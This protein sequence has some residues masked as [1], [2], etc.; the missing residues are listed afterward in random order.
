MDIPFLIA[1]I[2]LG[3]LLPRPRGLVGLAIAWS[4][5]I[6]LVGW[7]PLG[8]SN[9]HTDSVGFWLPWLVVGALGTGLVLV[10]GRFRA[11]RIRRATTS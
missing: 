2:M 1:A 11:R 3:L 6:A 7:G 8:N 10:G 5:C 9:V 4:L